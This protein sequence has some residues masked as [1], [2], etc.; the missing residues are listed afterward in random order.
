MRFAKYE[1]R[2]SSFELR[3]FFLLCSGL[4]QDR[5]GL[6]LVVWRQFQTLKSS[7]SYDFPP[8]LRPWG[9]VAGWF[10]TMNFVI[11]SFALTRVPSLA[12][13]WSIWMTIL[14]W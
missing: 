9:I 13:T 4:F 5:H 1:S 11:L 2:V 3:T 14:G 7:V 10:L 8:R 12:D 6:G